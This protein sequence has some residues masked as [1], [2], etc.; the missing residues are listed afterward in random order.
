MKKYGIIIGAILIAN[1]A[2]GFGGQGCDRN[3]ICPTDAVNVSR[4][5]KV[6]IVKGTAGSRRQ[7]LNWTKR[8]TREL[9]KQT[10]LEKSA[11]KQGMKARYR[12]SRVSRQAPTTKAETKI[13]RIHRI[14]KARRA[15]R[16]NK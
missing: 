10:P 5:A 11:I 12:G 9:R 13:Q 2:L 7:S 14:L 15:K 4:S 8:I 16:N 6:T 3:G 1:T